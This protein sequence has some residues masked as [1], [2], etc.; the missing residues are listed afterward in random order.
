[1]VE[2]FNRGFTFGVAGLLC[3]LLAFSLV[4]SVTSRG[5]LFVHLAVFEIAGLRCINADVATSRVPECHHGFAPVSAPAAH[6]AAIGVYLSWKPLHD[7][8]LLQRRGAYLSRGVS[9]YR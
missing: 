7:P 5:S 9:L 2:G 1:M 4:R 6:L 8:Q 3:W